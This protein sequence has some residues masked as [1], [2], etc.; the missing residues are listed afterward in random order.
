[1]PTVYYSHCSGGILSYLIPTPYD[2]N[3]VTDLPKHPCLSLT[4]SCVQTLSS[5]HGRYCIVMTK[6]L[7]YTPQLHREFVAYKGRVLSKDPNEGFSH[8]IAKLEKA[9]SNEAFED[10]GVV[11]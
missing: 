8:V 1:M 11:K 9:L 10:D 2:F 4:T 3:V 7:E 5:R 6:D